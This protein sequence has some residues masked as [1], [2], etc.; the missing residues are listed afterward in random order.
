MLLLLLVLLLVLTVVLLRGG[1]TIFGRWYRRARLF[2]LPR[3]LRRG[4]GF[5]LGCC[6]RRRQQDPFRFLPGTLRH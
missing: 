3:K 6:S 2:G 1:V 5:F 4:V